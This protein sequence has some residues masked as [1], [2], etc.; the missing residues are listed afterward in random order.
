MR[1]LAVLTLLF[2]LGCGSS[3]KSGHEEKFLGT[4]V[5]AYFSDENYRDLILGAPSSSLFFV[6]LNPS[7]GP[8]SEADLSLSDF[9]TA[10]EREGKTP[11]GY[12]YTD[13]GN[14]SMEEVKKEIDRWLKLYPQVEGFFIDEVPADSGKLAYYKDI[15]SYVKS[16][17]SYKVILNP[18]ILP[19]KAYFSVG[20]MVVIFESDYGNLNSLK[21]S[22][23]RSRSICIVTGVPENVYK[24]VLNQVR[25]RCSFVYVTNDSGKNPYDTLPSYFDEEMKAI[26][27][28]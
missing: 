18:G 15:Y 23:L 21:D 8:G 20:D 5:P 19:D 13:W 12:V 3:G 16:K 11:V 4:V 25:D 7:N 9:I 22:G 28:G 14:R 26:F 6:I 2:L 27:G 1:W 17:G 24:D 10:L